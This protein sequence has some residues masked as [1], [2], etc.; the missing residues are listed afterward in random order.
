MEEC[1]AE[2]GG[3]TKGLREGSGDTEGKSESL[4]TQG[5]D[6]NGEGGK[7]RGWGWGKRPGHKSGRE[8]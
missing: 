2:G 6:G 5:Q 1:G 4:G 3:E 7:E 8:E